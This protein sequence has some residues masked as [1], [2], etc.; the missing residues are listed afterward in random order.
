MSAVTPERPA[1]LAD[2]IDHREGCPSDRIE[3][4]IGDRPRNATYPLGGR[5]EVARCIDCGRDSY[6]NLK[7]E[8]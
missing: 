4:F 8:D 6:R 3:T 1:T 2:R 5:V 7:T